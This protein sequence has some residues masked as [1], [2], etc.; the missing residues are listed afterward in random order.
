[1]IKSIL[2]YIDNDEKIEAGLDEII[3]V[4]KHQTKKTA[5]LG[6]AYAYYEIYL[7]N[8]EIL[9]ITSLMTQ[10]LKIPGTKVEIIDCYFPSVYLSERVLENDG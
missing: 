4:I 8:G 6:D 1:M 2:C 7:K 9:N 5:L 3:K 10:R